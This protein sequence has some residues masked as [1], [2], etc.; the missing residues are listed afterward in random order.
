M[1]RSDVRRAGRALSWCFPFEDGLWGGWSLLGCGTK[2]WGNVGRQVGA[3]GEDAP[4]RTEVVGQGA[5]SH[6][7]DTDVADGCRLDRPGHDGQ[8]TVHSGALAEQQV[9]RA[10]A[11]EMDHIHGSL[12]DCS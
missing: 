5:M 4:N 1:R 9:L 7:L 8:S 10:A 11:H 12:G 3:S 6:C 2:V